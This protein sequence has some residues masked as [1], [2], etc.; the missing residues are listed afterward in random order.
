MRDHDGGK[1]S[2]A[3][4]ELPLSLKIFFW[5]VL[6]FI[7]TVNVLTFV[8][9]HT[10]SPKLGMEIPHE[11]STDDLKKKERERISKIL[12]KAD[13]SHRL[14]QAEGYILVVSRLDPQ[15]YNEAEMLIRREL[16]QIFQEPAENFRIVRTPVPTKRLRRLQQL[17]NSINKFLWVI[18]KALVQ[19]SWEISKALVQFLWEISKALAQFLWE[20]IKYVFGIEREN[21]SAGEAISPPLFAAVAE[22]AAAPLKI[23][24]ASPKKYEKQLRRRFKQ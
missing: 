13:I 16:E 4:N 17:R 3:K 6:V 18:A 11:E 5:G 10:S 9:Q 2:N 15:Q 7:I 22:Q 24:K 12:E 23:Y 1:I 20:I 14:M 8:V 19:L 21:E